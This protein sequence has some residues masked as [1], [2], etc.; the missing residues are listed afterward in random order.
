MFGGPNGT[1]SAFKLGNDSDLS[2]RIGCIQRECDVIVKKSS[3]LNIL[4]N[5]HVL[6]LPESEKHNFGIVFVC[7]FVC[8]LNRFGCCNGFR[9]GA[10]DGVLSMNMKAQT[11]NEI[12]IGQMDY[13]YPDKPFQTTI[14]VLA[15]SILNEN[16]ISSDI[17]T[18]LLASESRLRQVQSWREI[19][20]L[21]S[22]ERDPN[23]LEKRVR[24]S[25]LSLTGGKS[26]VS[27]PNRGTRI[28]P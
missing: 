5:F 4:M 13:I 14:N 28:D 8:P 15:A 6:D 18:T 19:G 11:R 24:E 25:H 17:E 23:R 20:V 9:Y 21:F 7:L 2:S 1:E 16:L 12:Q 27:Q 10:W 3:D 22:T 26:D